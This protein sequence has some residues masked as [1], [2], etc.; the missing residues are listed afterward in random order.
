MSDFEEKLNSILSN[1]DAMAR[2]MNLAQSLGAMVPQ[3]NGAQKPEETP[4]PLPGF[5][6]LKTLDFTG[7]FSPEAS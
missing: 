2:V 7:F 4:L 3:E 1:P 5:E 6:M